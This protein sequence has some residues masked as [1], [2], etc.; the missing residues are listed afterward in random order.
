MKTCE[1][2]GHL[3]TVSA[4]PPGK[5][6]NTH[7]FVGCLDPSTSLDAVEKRKTFCLCQELNPVIQHVDCLCTVKVVPVF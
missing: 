4:L 5:G 6:P 2:S 1:V 3:H 7:G